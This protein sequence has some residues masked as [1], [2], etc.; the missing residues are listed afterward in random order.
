MSDYQHQKVIRCK[1]DLKKLGI[2]DIYDL[3]DMYP[4]LFGCD[5]IKKFNIAPVEEMEYIDYVL[6]SEYD[7]SSDFG[8]SRYLTKKELEK[9]LP[10]FQQIIPN[11]QENN[12]RAVEF[13][14]YNCSEAPLYFDVVDQEWL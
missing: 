2:S 1:I 7:D 5:S 3:E 11:V 8:H 4:D 12:L 9:Y 10:I 6:F 14:W 13:C